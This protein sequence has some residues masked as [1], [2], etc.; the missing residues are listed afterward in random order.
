MVT[1]SV[2]GGVPGVTVMVVVRVSANHDAVIV[3]VRVEVTANVLTGNAPLDAPPLTTMSA[4]TF[5][6]AGSL[7]DSWTFAPLVA[8]VNR[9]VPVAAPPPTTVVGVTDT[10]E[11]E[12]PAGV[13]WLT[14]SGA[15]RGTLGSAAGV[16]TNG[17]GGAA[18][19]VGV[20]GP[21]GDPPRAPTP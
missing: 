15:V 13:A 7:V 11:S 18:A 5:T 8:A 19:G 12:G 16:V 17:S 6:T 4:G 1:R 21:P 9:T 20:E 3:T 2:A 14:P 10:D